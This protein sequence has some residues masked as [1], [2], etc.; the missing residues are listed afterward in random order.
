MNC[1]MVKWKVNCSMVGWK[2]NCT[3]VG[4]MMNCTMVGCYGFLKL[5]I[6]YLLEYKKYINNVHFK[7]C[8]I[9]ISLM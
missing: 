6:S 8:L 3:M 7:C 5:L 9:D 1:R 2:V 4:W